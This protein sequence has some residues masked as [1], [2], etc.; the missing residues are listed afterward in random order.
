MEAG[1]GP[2]VKRR[3]ADWTS[4]VLGL[5]SVA[6]GGNRGSIKQGEALRGAWSIPATSSS[7]HFPACVLCY[8][9]TY[10]LVTKAR[11]AAST[12]NLLTPFHLR[13]PKLELGT[14]Q[15]HLDAH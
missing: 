8:N 7:A 12:P 5:V 10:C 2:P 6:G 4:A 14:Q 11:A 15:R 9:I 1:G 3:C 13:T